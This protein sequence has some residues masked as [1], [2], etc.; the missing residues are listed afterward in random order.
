MN[1][2]VRIDRTRCIGSRQCVYVAPGTFEQDSDAKAV[3]SDPRGEPEEK[4]VHAVTACPV[5]AISLRIGAATIT[6]EDL[7]DWTRGPHAE[8]PLVPL[9]EQLCEDHHEL[10]VALTATT[11]A[12]TPEQTSEIC[13]LTRSHLKSENAVYSAMAELVDPSLIDAF[14]AGHETMVRA[15][16]ELIDDPAA[17]QAMSAFEEIVRRHIRLEETVL[18]PLALAAL[19]R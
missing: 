10:G 7:R 14:E 16:D 2:E 5:E 9:L 15:L 18:F 12:T 4:V 13:C 6:A 19:A 3:V 17:G 11:L 8:H 1:L